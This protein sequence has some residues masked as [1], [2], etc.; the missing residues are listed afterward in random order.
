VFTTNCVRAAPVLYC[1]SLLKTNGGQARAIVVNA[2]NAN[3]CTGP[4]GARDAQAMAELAALGLR[5]SS[6][7]VLVCSTGIIGRRLPMEKLAAGIARVTELIQSARGGGEFAR[8][9]MTTDLAPKSAAV[10][11][12]LGAKT[13]RLAGVCKG[14]GMIAPRL[15]TM[16]AFLATD[17]A[18]APRA[19]RAALAAAAADTF[20]CLTVDGDNSTNDTVLA[21]ASGAAG[22]KPITRPGGRAFRAFGAALH[23]VCD[24]LARQ[25][26]ADGEGA[27]HLV[28]VL[29][30]GAPSDAAARAIARTIAESPLVKTAIAGND[31]NWGRI[32]CAAGRSGVPLK[33]SAC[34]LRVCGHELYRAG[35][36]V[37]FDARE[38][39]A[40]LAKREVEILFRAG[41]GRGRARFYTCDLTH[42][43]ITIN[44]EYHT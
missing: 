18:I 16:L 22:N 3:A 23:C 17:A 13:A 15:A 14:S 28:T 1:E 8:A 7:E 2:G 42:G 20:N 37:E 9:I 39:S 32:L 27:Q 24:S 12:R 19:L 4:Q 30:E 6:R 29:V 35:Q 43:Y 38:V 31:P 21:L 33:A 41:R 5:C 44:A 34:S 11:V 10:T 40:A 36:P 25:I 26:A